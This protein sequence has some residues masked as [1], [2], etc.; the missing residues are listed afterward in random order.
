MPIDPIYE[1][2]QKRVHYLSWSFWKGHDLTLLRHGLNLADVKQQAWVEFMVLKRQWPTNPTKYLVGRLVDWMRRETSWTRRTRTPA[3]FVR[4][5]GYVEDMNNPKRGCNATSW[6]FPADPVD[7]EGGEVIQG[8]RMHSQKQSQ[9]AGHMINAYIE[10]YTMK[11]IGKKHNVSEGR[12]CQIVGKV[13]STFRAGLVMACLL[14]LCVP[15]AWAQEPPVMVGGCQY[16]QWQA[17]TESDLAG[18]QIFVN[19][20]GEALP[21]VSVD[22]TDTRFACSG[23]PI[24]EGATYAI[25]MTAYDKSGNVSAPSEAVAFTWPDLTAPSVPTSLCLV[26]T[27]DGQAKQLCLTIQ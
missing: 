8:L 25:Q 5:F 2:Y 4:S 22:S 13:V 18:Y 7:L 24:V 11:E 26:V 16:V 15:G 3:P 21:P 14:V 9:R 12:V 20:D 27:I 19:K 1:K 23:L 10:G 6:E 17:N